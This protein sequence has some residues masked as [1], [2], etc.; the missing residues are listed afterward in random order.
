MNNP[1]AALVNHLHL[2]EI[3]KAP[4]SV[5]E[6]VAHVGAQAATAT[7]HAAV[8]AVKV[9][10]FMQHIESG[11]LTVADDIIK[12]TPTAVAI[13]N[14]VLPEFT[15]LEDA[16]GAAVV[17]AMTL[18]KNGIIM[19]QQTHAALP[20]GDLKNTVKKTAV[21]V[22]FAPA[23]LTI[24]NQAGLNVNENRV[25]KI[26]DAIVQILGSNAVPVPVPAPAPL[27]VAA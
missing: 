7:A 14:A 27:P 8:S 25:S 15:L 4:V 2:K 26:I 5:V 24:L 21:M 12:Y 9:V 17:G 20:S 19:V 11:G 13:A 10:S 23:V 22:T 16:S 6:G 1:L 3:A 18:L